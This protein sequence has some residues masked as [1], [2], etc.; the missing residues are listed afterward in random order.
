MFDSSERRKLCQNERE[1]N[2]KN[3][4][5]DPLQSLATMERHAVSDAWAKTKK[6]EFM[7]MQQQSKSIMM[8]VN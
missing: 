8:Y 5:P 3:Q 2:K 1:T 4:S 7:H 6:V